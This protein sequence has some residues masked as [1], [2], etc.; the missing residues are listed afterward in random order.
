MSYKSYSDAFRSEAIIRLVV[1]GYNLT[2]TSE[3]LGIPVRTLRRWDKD[4][5]KKTT[6]ELLRRA[7]ENILVSI[8]RTWDGN[9]WAVAVGILTDKILLFQGKATSRAETISKKLDGFTD[10]EF[11]DI[12]EEA[13]SILAEVARGGDTEGDLSSSG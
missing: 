9:S 11:T 2:K 13:N 12:L 5:P 3:E 4:V 10:D 8:P 7:L 1:N 6:E